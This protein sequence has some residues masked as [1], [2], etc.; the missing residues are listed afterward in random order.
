[1]KYSAVMKRHLLLTLLPLIFSTSHGFAKSDL[2][3]LRARC[4]EQ[5]RQIRELEDENAKLRSLHNLSV[6]SAR[7]KATP[8]GAAATEP[9][10]NSES[11][12]GTATYLVKRGDSWTRI[13]D[14]FDTKPAT[15]AQLN[16]MKETSMIHAGQKL[17]VPSSNRT[18][19]AAAASKPAPSATPAPAAPALNGKTHLVKK[20]ETFSSIAKKYGVSSERLIAANPSIKPTAMRPGQTIQLSQ[21]AAAASPAAIAATKKPSAP[22]AV[23]PAPKATPTAKPAVQQAAARTTPPSP[24]SLPS[25]LPA[26]ERPATAMAAASPAPNPTK[27]RYRSVMIDG[28]TTF[29]EFATQHGIDVARLNEL[30]ALELVETTVLAKGSELYVPAQP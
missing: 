8:G 28:K 20:G 2:E 1:M 7:P 6:N 26:P 15:L 19:A 30:N 21:T 13:A 24:A 10:R 9:E 12:G 11:S 16:G 5:E 18:A 17:K 4:A 3:V 14:K 25:T 27:A 23:T 22:A 29:G